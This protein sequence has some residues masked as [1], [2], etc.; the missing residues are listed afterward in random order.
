[1]IVRGPLWRIPGETF[2]FDCWVSGS[3]ITDYMNKSMNEVGNHEE[4]HTG[5]H[6][7]KMVRVLPSQGCVLH[8]VAIALGHT[9]M[10]RKDTSGSTRSPW[11]RAIERVVTGSQCTS[12]L[13]ETQAWA[14][15]GIHEAWKCTSVRESRDRASYRTPGRGRGLPLGVQELGAGMVCLFL[16]RKS[17]HCTL[18]SQSNYIPRCLQ[19][20]YISA[21]PNCSW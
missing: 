16:I 17:W 1:M 12:V 10:A 7:P 11:R 3:S 8:R 19:H 20:L 14:P 5:T 15:W 18:L 6:K 2:F 21:F 4:F 9:R 13:P